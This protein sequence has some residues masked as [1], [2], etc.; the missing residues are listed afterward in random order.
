MRLMSGKF[1]LF[2]K[3]GSWVCLDGHSPV[4][5]EGCETANGF[6]PRMNRRGYDYMGNLELT[7]HDNS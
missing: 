1:D 5:R 3:F 4:T 6:D 2:F 7:R